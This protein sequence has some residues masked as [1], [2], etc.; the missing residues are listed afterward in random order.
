MK[1]LA[2]LLLAISPLFAT[3]R[4]VTSFGAVGNGVTNNNTALTNAY[5]ACAP[6]DTTTFPTGTFLITAVLTWPNGCTI[7]SSAGA[8][9]KGSFQPLMKGVFDNAQNLTM[10][11]MTFDGGG[12][13][14]PGSSTV[15]SG[16]NIQ[17]IGNTFQNIVRTPS[18]SFG[19]TVGI[20]AGIGIDNSLI[21]GN[22]F[23]N[24]YDA[25][26]VPP[27]SGWSEVAA[28]IWIYDSDSTT[29]TGNVFTNTAQPLH[30]TANE[31]GHSTFILTNNT[32]A[33]ISRYGF[34][35]QGNFSLNTVTVTGN[36]IGPYMGLN[37][38][39]GGINGQAGI[40]LALGGTNHHITNNSV[41]GPNAVNPAPK[42]SDAFEVEGGCGLLVQS[43]VGGHFQTAQLSGFNNSCAWSSINNTWCDMIDTSGQ[44]I[45]FIET[46]GTQPTTNTGNV[47]K[48][49]CS[50]V[51]FPPPFSIPPTVSLVVGG[52][53]IMR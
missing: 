44:N 12:I 34:E 37:P 10:T 9:L 25:G 6:G 47:Y 35:I 3:T 39:Q 16:N 7:S 48:P 14:F 23:N 52:K 46:N 40:S 11:G 5:A 50:D 8:I 20:L 32:A 36:Y 18:L 53:V 29:V 51:T 30:Y 49:S 27:A 19:L 28:A 24:I 21:S 22:I 31:N 33:M 26:H 15:H 38:F 4:S 1:L 2:F 43:N 45:V 42:Q 17:I 41:Q 13:D